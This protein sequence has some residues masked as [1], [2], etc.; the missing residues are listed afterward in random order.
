ME[1]YGICGGGLSKQFAIIV[2]CA[3]APV[4]LEYTIFTNHPSRPLG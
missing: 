4:A 1:I 2:I 3:L